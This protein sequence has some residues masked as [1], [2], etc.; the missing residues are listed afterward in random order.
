MT[1]CVF[2]EII[3]GRAS[4]D[5]VAE[6]DDAI[7]FVPLDPVTTGHTLVVPRQHVADALENPAV[8]ALTMRRAAELARGQCNL[9]TSVGA[10]ATQ[11]IPHLHI[12][13]VPRFSGDGLLLP[14]SDLTAARWR[15]DA[16]GLAELLRL[17]VFV[18]WDD[19]FHAAGGY[20]MQI[21][22]WDDLMAHSQAALAAHDAVVVRAATEK[23]LGGKQ[24]GR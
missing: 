7:A 21:N 24:N 5:M 3:A 4:A 16:E 10:D 9:I 8:T 19:L 6:W 20:P 22:E 12:H 2:C 17:F 11:S 18:D 1:A 14:W 23:A 13:V 15:R